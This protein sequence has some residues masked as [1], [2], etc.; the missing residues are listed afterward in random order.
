MKGDD[1]RHGD[2]RLVTMEQIQ[3]WSK[4]KASVLYVEDI[5]MRTR[6]RKVVDSTKDPFAT[7]IRYHVK[8]FKKYLKPVYDDKCDDHMQHMNLSDIKQKFL[9][10]VRKKIFEDGEART[11]KRLTLDYELI[12]LNFGVQIFSC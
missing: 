1:C 9:E 10:E 8:C 3:T 2:A 7:H 12:R 5:D 11:L 6:L 4:F